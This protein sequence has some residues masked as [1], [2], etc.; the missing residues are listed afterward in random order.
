[1]QVVL[2]L[3]VPA[4]AGMAVVAAAVVTGTAVPRGAAVV[5]MAVMSGALPMVVLGSNAALS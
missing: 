1:M 4:A 5:G 2:A 3:L